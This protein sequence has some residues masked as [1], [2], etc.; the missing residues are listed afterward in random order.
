M[1]ALT[2]LLI[3]LALLGAAACGE[4]EG[5]DC[6]EDRNCPSSFICAQIVGGGELGTC[7]QRCM[8]DDDCPD[9]ERCDAD[10]AGRFYCADQDV[11]P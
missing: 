8:I 9:D 7:Q 4:T 11:G 5:S 2:R 6:E 10:R 3:P 1:K